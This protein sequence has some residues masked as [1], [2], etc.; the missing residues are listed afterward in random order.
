MLDWD[1]DT[2]T[3]VNAFQWGRD[4]KPHKKPRWT[5]YA[6]NGKRKDNRSF[7]DSRR[8]YLVVFSSLG[9][10]R[11]WPPQPHH[12]N[13]GERHWR[14][15]RWKVLEQTGV[16]RCQ[17]KQQKNVERKQLENESGEERD[18]IV[19]TTGK[20]GLARYCLRQKIDIGSKKSYQEKQLG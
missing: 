3:S 12:R 10:R 14:R 4:L 9:S 11:S 16:E 17:W 6:R 1:C 15:A 2:K 18:T 7:K 13:D 5:R 8:T 19:D 20:S